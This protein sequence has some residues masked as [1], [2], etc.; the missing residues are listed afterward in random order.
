M[1]LKD[2]TIVDVV[3]LVSL[4]MIVWIVVSIVNN[5]PEPINSPNQQNIPLHDISTAF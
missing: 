4:A 5:Q 3:G 1:K 2:L